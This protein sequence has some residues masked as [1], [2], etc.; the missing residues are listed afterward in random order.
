MY[1]SGFDPSYESLFSH[2][3][4]NVFGG[5]FICFFYYFLAII[6]LF[7]HLLFIHLFFRSVVFS[8]IMFSFLEVRKVIAQSF[9][10]LFF[11]HS[12]FHVLISS[13]PF[14]FLSH[15]F[16]ISTSPSVP[17]PIRFFSYVCSSN[18]SEIFSQS[19]LSSRGC[20]LTARN[21]HRAQKSDLDS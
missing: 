6:C 3:N 11:I 13:Y 15:S 8:F 20:N 12:H 5:S 19:A 1:L 7:V 14:I 18:G 9:F 21:R 10:F 4:V 17:L 16:P 2:S